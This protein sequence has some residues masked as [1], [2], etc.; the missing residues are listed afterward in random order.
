[1]PAIA[2]DIKIPKY[3]NPVVVSSC[4]CEKNNIKTVTNKAYN[5]DANIP[6]TTPLNSHIFD[7]INPVINAPNITQHTK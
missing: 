1:M 7:A 3:K 2:E 6:E 5:N 4:P